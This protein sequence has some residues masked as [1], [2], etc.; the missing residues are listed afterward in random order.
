MVVCI[1]IAGI[2]I[3]TEQV[4]CNRA[5][6]H[7][8]LRVDYY[9]AFHLLIIAHERLK[10]AT[11]HVKRTKA[12]LKLLLAEILSPSPLLECYTQ[13]QSIQEQQK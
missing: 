11:R 10:R 4:C 9:L 7:S 13:R 1:G 3:G 8:F 2:V 6:S 5:R 12:S